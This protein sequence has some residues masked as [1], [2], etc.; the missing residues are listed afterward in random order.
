MKIKWAFLVILAGCF[1][2]VMDPTSRAV[3]TTAIDRVRAKG[4]LDAQD[5]KVIDEFLAQAVQELVRT[6]DLATI[7]KRRTVI[8]SRKGT[9][10]Q[11]AQQFSEAAHKYIQAGLEE[12][13]T[14][15]EERK[16]SVMVN[17]L[18]LI[19]GLEDP[20]L[21]DLAMEM[22]KSDSMVV[23]Y[24]AVSCLTNPAMLEQLKGK[25]DPNPG[26]ARMIAERLSQVVP[27]SNAEILYRMTRFVAN[28]N[29]PQSEQLLLQI[30]DERMKR[31]AD[32]TVKYELYDIAILQLLESKIPAAPS[33]EL[34]GLAS[35]AAPRKPEVARRFAQLYSYA[36]QRYVKGK[37]AG[38][39]SDA[40]IRHLVS[41]LVDVDEKCV[42]QLLGQPQTAMRR[43]VERDSTQAVMEEHDRLLGSQST[44]GQLPTR[45]GFDYGTTADGARRTAPIPL[46]D[47]P[48][49]PTTEN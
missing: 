39:L 41:V 3:N 16:T 32:W 5:Y 29:S 27:T 4:V 46:S 6:R 31:Y 34:G 36:I 40:Q 1:F 14:L 10:G 33:S 11:Y 26:D 7:A 42:S 37:N 47:P 2:L 18:I 12:A 17:L 45:L 43:A 23:R 35:T 25:T 9:Q 38:V 22:L 19:D 20:R 13:Q 30:A 44:P 24:W 49:R 21:N 8:L 15:P 48:A 28:V